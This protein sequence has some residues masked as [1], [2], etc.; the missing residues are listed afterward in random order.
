MLAAQSTPDLAISQ[1]QVFPTGIAVPAGDAVGLDSQDGLGSAEIYGYLVPAAA[2]P[3]NA[4]SRVSAV[5]PGAL[6]NAKPR[7]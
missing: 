7:H 5:R 3:S 2:V 6:A 4:L 1:N